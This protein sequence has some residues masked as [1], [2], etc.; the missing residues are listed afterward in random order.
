MVVGIGGD[1]ERFD[2]VDAIEGW[3]ERERVEW[4][5]VVVGSWED[6][7]VEALRGEGIISLEV[8]NLGGS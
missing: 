6:D 2:E 1:K 5:E 8:L 4:E 7:E 3:R